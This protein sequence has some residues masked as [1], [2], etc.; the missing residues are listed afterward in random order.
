M[1]T[2]SLF[3]TVLLFPVFMACE[4]DSL[5]LTKEQEQLALNQKRAEIENLANSLAC[6]DP[7]GWAFTGI[8]GKACGGPTGYIAYSTSINVD[9]FLKKVGEFTIAEDN[10]NKKWNIRSDCSVPPQPVGVNC[11]NGV[12]V[13]VFP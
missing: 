1:K 4:S 5:G 2:S 13:L 7:S 8:G 12:A 10:F 6:V 9:E 3:L 11:E